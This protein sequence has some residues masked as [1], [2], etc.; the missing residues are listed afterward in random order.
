MSRVTNSKEIFIEKA[1]KIHNNKYDYSKVE[2]VNNH[3]KVCIIC[4][5]H[6]E[7][8]QTPAS[9][10]S[11]RGCSKCSNKEKLTCNSFVKKAKKIHG[12]KYNYSKVNYVNNKTKV[13]IICPIHGEFW[14]TPNN[15]L[16]GVKCPKCSKRYSYTTEEWVKEAQ[17]IHGE[18]YDY[19]KVKYIDAKTKVCIICLKHGEFWQTPNNHL[20]KH[21][22]PKCKCE[23]VGKISLEKCRNKFTEEAS[24]K[25]QNIYDYSLVEYR[26]NEN[27]VDIICKK[28]GIFSIT[29]HN[30]LRG[31]GC[32][33]CS[34]SL[35]ENRIADILTKHNIIYEREKK[36]DWLIYKSNL[37][38]D[39]YLPKYNI[40]IE[41]QG[42][43]H[44]EPVNWCKHDDEWANRNL[45]LVKDRDSIKKS[46]CD[47]N[48][49]KLFYI[50][51]DEDIESKVNAILDV[52]KK[53]N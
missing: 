18:L 30:H 26:G 28:H 12:N 20:N 3:T 42:R 32:P 48:G 9:H 22:C 51:Y 17:K 39:F 35:G 33:L 40:G 2:Y 7:F 37:R 50:K 43:G 41:Y 47:S 49:V 36:F 14:Q 52:I 31:H 8:W 13:C 34:K 24:L 5:K 53:E 21:G 10:L 25:H 44:Y 4:P 27:K 45:M 46:L 38:L 23:K 6:G 29:P 11:G 15:H 19:S 16:N 1:A